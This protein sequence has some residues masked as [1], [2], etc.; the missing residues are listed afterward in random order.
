M[1]RSRAPG[2][3]PL[4]RVAPAHEPLPES[5]HPGPR[6]AILVAHGMGQQVRFETLDLLAKSLL[7]AAGAADP[8]ARV[9][10]DVRLLER[11]GRTIPRAEIR[12]PLPGGGDREVHLYEI[13][14]A[15][16]TEG[17]I[18]TDEVV[19]FLF[20]AGVAA[21]LHASVGRKGRGRF[22]R[23]LF[24]DWQHFHIPP[25]SALKLFASVAFLVLLLIGDALALAAL[26]SRLFH[27]A[28]AAHTAT[29]WL[30]IGGA[31]L[32]GSVWLSAFLQQYVGDVVIYVS[33][34]QVNRFY[35][36]RAAIQQEG[37]AVARCLYALTDVEGRPAYD[38][39]TVVGHSLGSVIAYDT[40]NA[41]LR[42]SADPFGAGGPVERTRALITFG[43][44][45]DKTAFVF[46]TQKRE[47]YDVREA[48]AAAMQPLVTDYGFRPAS[49]LNLW[50][51]RDWVSDALRFYDVD[52]EH[53]GE[54]AAAR[55]R[56]RWV[57]NRRVPAP[58]DPFRA[59]LH[60]W[61]SDALA[62]A[63]Y[64]EATGIRRE[65]ARERGD[66]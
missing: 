29:V 10:L 65:G 31:L 55:A 64:E 51:R 4:A 62:R 35:E 9:P 2:P 24:G 5:R 42:E 11:E 16:L 33:S 20:R 57:E 44:P 66:V 26:V 50:S 63:L 18:R 15:P 46:R 30:V 13:Y 7:R 37:L 38:R 34:Y 41:I 21:L 32:A 43:S 40:L 23:H 60:Y 49:W 53:R 22:K 45:L 52:E 59:H 19:R 27:G 48:L 1:F 28:F 12:L 39:I 54:P 58:F 3:P 47:T 61:T 17:R 14:W 8:E 36:T 25:S 6:S 56:T